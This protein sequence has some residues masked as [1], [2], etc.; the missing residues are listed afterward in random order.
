M[1]NG[2]PSLFARYAFPPNS[3]GYC[4]PASTE[5]RQAIDVSNHRELLHTVRAFEGAWPYL[6][7]IAGVTGR[8]PLDRDVVAAYW[9]GN[10]LLDG[11]DALV[12]GN[13]MDERF[14]TR[15]SGNV[16]AFMDQVEL[17]RPTH[18][19]HV[20]CVYPWV[21][22][23]RDGVES[24]ALEVLDRC[25]IRWGTVVSASASSA[26][27]RSRPLEW[28]GRS[29]SLGPEIVET[30]RFEDADEPTPGSIVS[31]HWDYVC[32]TLSARSVSRLELETRRHLDIANR[33]PRAIEA[34][35][36]R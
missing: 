22:L 2:G 25:R 30:V 4:G 5:W 17:G 24:S 16:V 6:E 20:F 14:R 23:L 1:T 10:S 32:E 27:V 12:W 33:A 31:M 28:D 21:G 34:R 9:I 8:D 26:M 11:M 36:E 35:L 29:L 3:L 15:L 13:S 19:F 7:L 18:A